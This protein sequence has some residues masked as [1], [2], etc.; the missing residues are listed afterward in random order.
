MLHP[1]RNYVPQGRFFT[2]KSPLHSDG[3]E[4]NPTRARDSSMDYSFAPEAHEL[5]V[6]P[7]VLQRPYWSIFQVTGFRLW[8]KLDNFSSSLR[9]VM[10]C[11]YSFHHVVCTL[12]SNSSRPMSAREFAQLLVTRN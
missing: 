3:I 11:V 2:G 8:E 5:V 10:S 1:Q 7:S 9:F 6:A 12:I 4:R